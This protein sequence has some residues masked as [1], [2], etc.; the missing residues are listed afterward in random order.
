[1]TDIAMKDYVDRRIDDMER[2]FA[3]RFTSADRALEKAETALREYKTVSNE[4]RAALA[5]QSNRMATRVE[6][7][8]LDSTVEAVRRDKANLDGRLLVIAIGASAVINWLLM[9]FGR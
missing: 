3:D 1:M 6:L 4:W 7:D 8:A 5:D 2:R 9:H